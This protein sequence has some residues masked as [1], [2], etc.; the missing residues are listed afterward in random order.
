MATGSSASVDKGPSKDERKAQEESAKQP[1][2]KPGGFKNDPP[3]PTNPNEARERHLRDL[4][5]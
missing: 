4:K 3:D 2:S 1:I 5:R